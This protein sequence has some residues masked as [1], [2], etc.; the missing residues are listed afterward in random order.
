MTAEVWNSPLTWKHAYQGL[1]DGFWSFAED[2]FGYQ[3]A[4]REDEIVL[5]DPEAGSTELIASMMEEWVDLILRDNSQDTA[6]YREATN[7]QTSLRGTPW[8]V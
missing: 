7:S 2:V 6:Y 5:F 4:I 8:K 1:A 3:F